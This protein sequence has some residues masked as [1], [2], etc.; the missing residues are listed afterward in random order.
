MSTDDDPPRFAVERQHLTER[1]TLQEIE[2]REQVEDPLGA[3]PAKPFG[4]LHEAWSVFSAQITDKD[5]LWAFSA[6]GIYRLWQD[7]SREGYAVVRDGR[8]GEFFLTVLKIEV[9]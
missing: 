5:E 8:P 4:H 7:E 6:R 3:V 1:L 2:V 9:P